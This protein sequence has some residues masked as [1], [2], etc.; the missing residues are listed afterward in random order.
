MGL[1]RKLR[2]WREESDGALSGPAIDTE[3]A[4]IDGS[5]L[6]IQDTEPTDA[7]EDD[8]WIDTSE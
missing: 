8:V 3:Q 2:K 7:E 1:L 6:Y 4:T 5:R